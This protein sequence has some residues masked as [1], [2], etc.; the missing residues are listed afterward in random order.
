MATTPSTNPMNDH[1]VKAIIAIL[2]TVVG[3]GIII[4]LCQSNLMVWASTIWIPVLILMA[5]IGGTWFMGTN[6]SKLLNEGK[7]AERVQEYVKE[8]AEE[9][10]VEFAGNP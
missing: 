9:L 4:W 10:E 8:H 5:L 1:Q 2:A 3:I 7:I 6:V